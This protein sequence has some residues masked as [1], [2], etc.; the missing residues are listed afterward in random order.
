MAKIPGGFG[1]ACWEMGLEAPGGIV[2]VFFFARCGLGC[3]VITT[4]I[5]AGR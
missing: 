5:I 3:E 4:Y 1:I 2:F